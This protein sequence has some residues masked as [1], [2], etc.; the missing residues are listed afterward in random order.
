MT[1]AKSQLH[2]TKRFHEY[3]HIRIGQNNA[4]RHIPVTMLTK[5]DY[6]L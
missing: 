5:G 3:R 6:M 4:N 1:T 2:V